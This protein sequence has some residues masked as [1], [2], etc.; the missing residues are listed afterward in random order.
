MM[1]IDFNSISILNIYSI[2]YRWIIK[3]DHNID[4]IL[5]SSMIC[6]SEKK[7]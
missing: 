7:L 1:S 2:D 6:S 3:R 4:N 5:I